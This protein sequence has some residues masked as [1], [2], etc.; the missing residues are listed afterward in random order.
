M[1]FSPCALSLVLCPAAKK[2]QLKVDN[3]EDDDFR[4]DFSGEVTT[5]YDFM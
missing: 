1:V 5:E 2:Q 3:P 4:G